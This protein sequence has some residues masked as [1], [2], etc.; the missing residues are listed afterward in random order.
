MVTFFMG[1]ILVVGANGFIGGEV[2]SYFGERAIG[3]SNIVSKEKNILKVDITK[4]EELEMFFEENDISSCVDFA[5]VSLSR[6]CE[7]NKALAYQVNVLGQKNLLNVC[8][9]QGV[10]YYY[11]S[12]VRL[13]DS[14]IGEVDENSEIKKSNCYTETKILAEKQIKEFFK[15]GKLKKAVI[16][17][18]SNTFGKDPNKERLIPTIIS[19]LKNGSI[20]LTNANTKFD[21]LYVRDIPKAIELAM[22]N[23]NGFGIFN[24]ASGEQLTMKEIAQRISRKL[25]NN[26]KVIIKDENELLHPKISI[27]KIASLG[28]VP[29]KFE[30]A[31][32]EIFDF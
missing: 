19:A 23:A 21:L 10:D 30:K 27:G 22:R 8:S 3:I 31:F 5:G 25:Q 7:E 15:E 4:K 28:F 29:T 16:F 12:T 13:Y 11:S 1:K 9:K 17:R 24:V 26:S 14:D 6:V 2:L 18:F 20:E 32:D